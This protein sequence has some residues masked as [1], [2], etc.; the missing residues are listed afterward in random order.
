M[1]ELMSEEG[2]FATMVLSKYWPRAGRVQ[3]ARAGHPYPLWVVNHEFRDLPKLDGIPIGVEFGAKYEKTEFTLSPGE[4]LLFITDGVT[5]AENE[6][7]EL[8]GLIIPE[9]AAK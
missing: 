9:D 5:E 4:A 7:S 6:K 8:F 2:F 3:T 1:Y